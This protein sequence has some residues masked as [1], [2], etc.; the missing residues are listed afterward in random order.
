MIAT[1]SAIESAL[2]AT[3]FNFEL[4]EGLK[5]FQQKISLFH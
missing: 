2:N 1:L 3:S 5:T 4:G